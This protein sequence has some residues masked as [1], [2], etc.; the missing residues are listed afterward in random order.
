[1]GNIKPLMVHL[2]WGHDFIF[3]IEEKVRSLKVGV[4]CIIS[5]KGS[6]LCTSLN[7]SEM[8]RKILGSS[9]TN[10]LYQ[11]KLSFGI[12]IVLSGFTKDA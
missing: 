2:V 5:V 10:S 7:T 1:M 6:V 9:F 4:E 11:C 3:Y 8:I 12:N